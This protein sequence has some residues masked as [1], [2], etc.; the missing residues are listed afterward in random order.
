MQSW[1]LNQVPIHNRASTIQDFWASIDTDISA[2]NDRYTQ[3]IYINIFFYIKK[4]IYTDV[5][6][7]IIWNVRK[8]A[9]Y[10]FFYIMLYMLHIII[11]NFGHLLPWPGLSLSHSISYIWRIWTSHPFVFGINFTFTS[12]VIAV[13]HSLVKTIPLSQFIVNSFCI[14]CLDIYLHFDNHIGVFNYRGQLA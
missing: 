14:Q 13:L 3:N 10:C 12:K 11:L 2:Y 1:L 9:C 4:Y 5:I 7:G 8:E 6:Q